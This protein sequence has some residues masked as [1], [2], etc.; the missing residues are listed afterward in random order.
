MQC[1]INRLLMMLHSKLPLQD[2][3]RSINL[4]PHEGESH[5][6][7][8]SFETLFKIM[9][10]ILWVSNGR[11]FVSAAAGR[12]CFNLHFRHPDKIQHKLIELLWVY[13]L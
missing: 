9:I 5:L 2:Q 4:D 12:P 7:G 11:S 13:T 3:S 1:M 8:N 10:Q 6:Y